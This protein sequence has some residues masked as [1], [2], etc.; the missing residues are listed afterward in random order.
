MPAD[1]DTFETVDAPATE[2]ALAT[3]VRA[4]DEEGRA[5]VTEGSG[6]KRHFGA[7]TAAGARRV[8]LSRLSRVIHEPADMILSV[9]AGATLAEV[10]RVLAAHGQWLPLDPPFVN[11][12]A[13]AGASIGGVLATGSSGPRRL[14]YGTAKDLLLGLRVLGAHGQITKSGGRV[15]KNVSGYDLHRPQVGAFGSLGVIV[16]AHFKVGA[17]PECSAL[18]ALPCATL[19][20]A[21]GLLLEVGASALR[22]VALEALDGAAAE[23]VRRRATLPGAP[24]QAVAVVGVEGSRAVFE[25][26]ARELATYAARG[27]GAPA[28]VESPTSEALW[29]ALADVPAMTAGDARV[30]VGARPHDLPAL[31]SALELGREAVRGVSVRSGTGLAFIALATSDAAPLGAIVERWHRLASARDGYAVVESAPLGL[32]GRE[33][34][35]FAAQEAGRL[36]AALRKAWDPKGLLNAGRM[37]P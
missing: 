4:M 24:G 19:D 36:H 3:L 15:V 29:A 37:A 2:D 11:V 14:G 35:P 31:L 34:L 32:P 13:P 9:G 8:S 5:L 17:R 25:R 22:P 16:E 23:L 26:H 12:G 20:D 6:T 27:S 10:Q 21:H 7:G 33:R 1:N 28:V 30:R 18:W